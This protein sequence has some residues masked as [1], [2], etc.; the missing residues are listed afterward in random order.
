MQKGFSSRK[1]LLSKMGLLVVE[2][3]LFGEG[4]Q[5]KEDILSREASW[6]GILIQRHPG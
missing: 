3:L 2:G 4:S 6:V 5:P 1:V